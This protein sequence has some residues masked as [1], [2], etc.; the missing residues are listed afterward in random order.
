MGCNCRGE[1]V[2]SGGR[3]V[4]VGERRRSKMER[5]V[6]QCGKEDVANGERRGLQEVEG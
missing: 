1:G 2:A 5:R 4:A 6:L 3:G